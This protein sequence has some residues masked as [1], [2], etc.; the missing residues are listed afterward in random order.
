[1]ER[2]ITKINKVNITW[3]YC[4][5][6]VNIRIILLLVMFRNIRD[7]KEKKKER[8]GMRMS[9]ENV[10]SLYQKFLEYY[11]K[12]YHFFF[13]LTFSFH[14]LSPFLRFLLVFIHYVLI[15]NSLRIV[16]LRE[17][18]KKKRGNKANK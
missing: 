4:R 7:Q 1:M 13:P 8:N 2:N 6:L 11:V 14:C 16:M 9:K 10:S 5:C 17:K 12:V 15:G 18:E 3:P